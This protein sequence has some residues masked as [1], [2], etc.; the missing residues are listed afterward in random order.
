MR[1]LS[2]TET[3]AVSGGFFL[4]LIWLL[5]SKIAAKKS[6]HVPAPAPK[7]H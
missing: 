3:E 6:E 4:G 2:T 7:Y 1:V 5:K